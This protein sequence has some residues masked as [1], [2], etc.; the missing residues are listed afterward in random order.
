MNPPIYVTNVP[1][2]AAPPFDGMLIVSMR[3]L[4]PADAERAVAITAP[5]AHAHGAPIH[6]GDPAAIGV[7]LARPDGGTALPLAQGEVPVFWACGVT[8]SSALRRARPPVCATH[9]PGAM[10]ITDLINSEMAR[11]P[12]RVRA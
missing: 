6:I 12:V 9:W 11:A 5:Y 8:P 3:P 10:L 7:D 4:S 1:T 2:V